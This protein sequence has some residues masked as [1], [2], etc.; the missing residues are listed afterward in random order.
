MQVA[1]LRVPPLPNPPLPGEG[2]VGSPRD[3]SLRR[4]EQ[5]V[6]FRLPTLR[7]LRDAVALKDAGQARRHLLQACVLKMTRDGLEVPVDLLPEEIAQEVERQQAQADPQADIRLD[8]SC[9]SCG[10]SWQE[11][12][13]IAAFF[14]TEI[15]ARAQRLLQE[16][17][18]LASAYGWSEAAILAL[19]SARRQLYLE[20]LGS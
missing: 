4:G 9:P 20:M 2:R 5:E 14:W 11:S 8:L 3:L 17:H 15:D 1:D 16:V 7:D 19:S 18:Q 10:H 13:D 6:H 12:F